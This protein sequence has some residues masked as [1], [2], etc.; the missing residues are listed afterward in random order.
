MTACAKRTPRAHFCFA[1]FD[2]AHINTAFCQY[3]EEL[4]IMLCRVNEVVAH[5]QVRTYF[6]CRPT[7]RIS[8]QALTIHHEK[9]YL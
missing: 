3:V 1:G 8:V 4:T 6:N 9:C 2:L 7:S 5:V